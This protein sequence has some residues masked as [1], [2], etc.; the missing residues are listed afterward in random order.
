MLRNLR[1]TELTAADMVATIR[2]DKAAAGI[3]IRR[4]D[5]GAVDRRR[6]IVVAGTMATDRAVTGE[7]ATG[8]RENLHQTTAWASPNRLQRSCWPGYPKTFGNN[9]AFT[10]PWKWE[11]NVNTLIATGLA[12]RPPE[13]RR[14]FVPERRKH[15]ALAFDG[16]DDVELFQVQFN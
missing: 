5:R 16:F 2:R 12:L 10:H 13:S 15:D 3:P 6:E 11:R 1:G 9:M 8:V 4:R 14:R 7:M